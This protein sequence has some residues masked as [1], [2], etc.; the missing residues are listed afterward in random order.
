VEA[1]WEFRHPPTKAFSLVP[2]RLAANLKDDY[3]DSTETELA[4]FA[5]VFQ[6]PP[7]AGILITHQFKSADGSRLVQ[8]GPSG[9]SVNWLKYLGFAGFRSAVGHITTQYFGATGVLDCARLGLRYINRMPAPVPDPF[10]G[11]AVRIEWPN[12]PGASAASAVSRGLFTFSNPDGELAV[13]VASPLEAK[14]T[15]DLDYSSQ[16]GRTMSVDEILGWS[17]IAHDRSYKAFRALVKDGLFDSW[18]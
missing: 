17:D 6:P 13:V 10:D 12:L 1:V 3:P 14:L 7:E 16:P 5:P 11:L 9:I 4:R 8:L 2:G 18:R 15:L